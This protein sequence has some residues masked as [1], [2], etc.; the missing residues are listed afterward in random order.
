MKLS[1]AHSDLFFKLMWRLQLH[2]NR[3]RALI[4]GVHSVEEY[5]ALPQTEAVKVRDVLWEDPGLIE[6][7]VADTRHDSGS[8]RIT[9]FILHFIR[10][11]SVV[12]IDIA[13]ELPVRGDKTEALAQELQWLS[14]ALTQVSG[15]PLEIR[16]DVPDP[17]VK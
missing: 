14:E 16:W 11:G 3:K 6:A 2:V 7:Y 15:P 12:Q 9:N 8:G 5:T 1:E 10:G 13:P 4:P 17:N